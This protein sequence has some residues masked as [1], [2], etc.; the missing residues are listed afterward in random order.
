MLVHISRSPDVVADGKIV[1]ENGQEYWHGLPELSFWFMEYAL[2][3]HT[4][5][6]IDEGRTRITWSETRQDNFK[7]P[8]ASEQYC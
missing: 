8:I 7:W 5:E 4:I 2:S 1:K 6:S 3:V